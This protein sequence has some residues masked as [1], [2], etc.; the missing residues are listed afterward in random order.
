MSDYAEELHKVVGTFPI[1][2]M[3]PVVYLTDPQGNLLLVRSRSRCYWELPGGVMV[4]GES[5]SACVRRSIY[6]SLGILIESCVPIKV[7]TELSD[8]YSSEDAA[9]VFPCYIGFL[10]TKVS[11]SFKPQTE[12]TQEIRFFA[13]WNIKKEKI[14]PLN[15]GPV[16][17]YIQNFPGGA[18]L[19]SLD[20][21]RYSD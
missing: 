10:P 9:N 15:W 4:P 5:I 14:F 3:T 8:G 13:T 19:R 6:S 21:E 2:E 1:V 7:F 18:P 12:R 16:N 11:G 20:L 17:F